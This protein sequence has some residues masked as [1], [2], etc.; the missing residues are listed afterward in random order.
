MKSNKP[1]PERGWTPQKLKTHFTQMLKQIKEFGIK[2]R[3]QKELIR[4]YQGE[5]MTMKQAILAN[6][7]QC[8]GYY[9]SSGSDKDCKNMDCP[10]YFYMPYS[11]HKK[12]HSDK[13]PRTMSEEHKSVMRNAREAKRLL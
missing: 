11:S 2:A 9:E 3:G 12:T 8:L 5:K 10:I 13:P 1:E 4:F 7:Y 6:C